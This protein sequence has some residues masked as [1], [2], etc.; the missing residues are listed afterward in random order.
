MCTLLNM[1]LPFEIRYLG[2]YIEDLGKRDYN[3]LRDTEHRANTIGDINDL[4]I[5][6]LTDTKTRRKFVLYM[7]LL[8]SNN[9][10]CALVHYQNLSNF[11]PQ[12]IASLLSSTANYNQEENFLDELLLLYTMALNHPAFTYEQKTTF[13]N[14]YMKLQEDEEARLNLTKPIINSTNRTTEVIIHL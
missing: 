8:H 6:G 10:P 2:T 12:L 4:G 3:E 1:C 14:I 5:L 11:D 13:G 7:S 9:Y